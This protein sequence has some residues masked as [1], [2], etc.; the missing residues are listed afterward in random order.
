MSANSC[1]KCHDCENFY[2]SW[3]NRAPLGCR[4]FGFKSKQL[5]SLVVLQS[6]GQACSYFRS[7][8]SPSEE[9]AE[10]STELLP[11]GCTISLSA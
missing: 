6:S 11:E 8:R 4:T 7:N 5:P 10:T 3:D 1:P 9:G 2:V